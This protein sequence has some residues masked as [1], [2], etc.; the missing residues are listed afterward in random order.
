MRYLRLYI[1]DGFPAIAISYRP[2]D[3][4]HMMKRTYYKLSGSTV[5]RFFTADHET[6]TY[7]GAGACTETLMIELKKSK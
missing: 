6:I 5:I 4:F 7:S 2:T 1:I 3:T